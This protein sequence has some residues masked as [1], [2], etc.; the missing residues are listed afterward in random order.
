MTLKTYHQV[1]G[2]G[3]EVNED[4]KTIKQKQPGF[5]SFIRMVHSHGSLSFIDQPVKV[6]QRWFNNPLMEMRNWYDDGVEDGFIQVLKRCILRHFD[7]VLKC[8][9]G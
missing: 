8:V 7:Y 4:E 2:L 5:E 1:G 9:Y 6:P 3:D